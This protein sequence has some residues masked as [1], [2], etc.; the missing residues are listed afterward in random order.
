MALC[1]NRKICIFISSYSHEKKTKQYAQCR[2]GSPVETNA[3][4]KRCRHR[5]TSEELYRERG[6]GCIR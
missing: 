1:E 2:Q 6:Q 3:V 4:Q 5:N